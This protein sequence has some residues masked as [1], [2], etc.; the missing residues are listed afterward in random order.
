MKRFLQLLFFSILITACAVPVAAEDWQELGSDHFIIYYLR[1]ADFAKDVARN[2]EKYYKKIAV[3]IG[4]PRYSEFWTW[5]N[6]VKIYIYLDHASYIKASEMPEWSHGMADYGKKK[7]MSYARSD[8]FVESVLPHEIAHLIFRD[9]VGFTG[10][11]PLWL[12]EGVAQWSEDKKKRAMKEL[13][14]MA[15]EEDQ[16]LSL[17]DLTELDIMRLKEYDKIHLRPTITKKGEPGVLIMDT[18]TLVS[19]FYLVSVSLIDF[20]ID[21]YG[22]ERFGQFCRELKDEK[23]VEEALKFAYSTNLQS[24]NEL[25]MKWRRSLAG[26]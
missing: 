3:G 16:L 1:D 2:A 20:L 23:S 11:I 15:Y 12:D 19:N 5:K 14:K 7:I 6:R 24:L 4:F 9:F 10:K 13:A 17:K 26:E 18:D 21:R 8:I 25:E 22:S